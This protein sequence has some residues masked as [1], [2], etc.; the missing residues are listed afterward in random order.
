MHRERGPEPQWDVIISFLVLH[1]D[2]VHTARSAYD[3][4]S[5]T[6]EKVVTPDC[7]EATMMPES[8]MRRVRRDAVLV[9][10]DNLKL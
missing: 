6:G 1:K 4:H 7:I 8:A 3:L 9:R 2:V 5:S 10:V